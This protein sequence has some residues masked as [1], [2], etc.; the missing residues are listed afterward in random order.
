ML[1]S[2]F[3]LIKKIFWTRECIQGSFLKIKENRQ[4]KL[5]V[6]HPIIN[7]FYSFPKIHKMLSPPIH[8]CSHM[9]SLL[10]PLIPAITG[11]IQDT[12]HLLSELGCVE[13]RLTWSTADVI[14]FYAVIP[15]DLAMNALQRFLD[16]YSSYTSGFISLIFIEASFSICG[17]VEE[18]LYIFHS[19]VLLP[20]LVT[21]SLAS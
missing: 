20:V 7:F 12:K 16:T 21:T 4:K 6:E 8:L 10:Q 11:Y 13:W 3:K 19:S 2:G 15:H 14:F 5:I 18:L 1:L 9:D 17:M